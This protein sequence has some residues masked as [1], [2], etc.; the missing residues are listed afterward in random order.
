M[1]FVM[2]EEKLSDD[3]SSSNNQ[4]DG[5]NSVQ[6][7]DEVQVCN[8][9]D[10]H[11]MVISS[12]NPNKRLRLQQR[13]SQNFNQFNQLLKGLAAQS[14]QQ[15]DYSASM[16]IMNSLQQFTEEELYGLSVGRRLSK[17]PQQ[18]SNKFYEP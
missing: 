10:S 17:L 13:K 9:G 3:D 6:Q 8:G 16:G 11:R 1:E 4:Q 7:Q 2:K 5:W 18:V 15:T 12:A 14:P